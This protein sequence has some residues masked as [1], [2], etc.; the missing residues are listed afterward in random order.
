MTN[1][2]HIKR[3]LQRLDEEVSRCHRMAKF[4][5]DGEDRSLA[6]TYDRDA[7]DLQALRDAVADGDFQ[8]AERIANKVDT[9]VRD[10]IPVRL[11]NTICKIAEEAEGED[12]MTT[13]T[14]KTTKKKAAKK[15]NSKTRPQGKKAAKATANAK[16]G[17]K[18]A[19]SRKDAEKGGGKLSCLDAAAKVLAE[20]KTAMT[21]RE[22]FDAMVAKGY[23]TSDVPTPQNTIYSA[24]LREINI[25]GKDSRFCK[26]ERGR[27]GLN[28]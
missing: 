22:M 13:K 23:W 1:K 26:V 27:F 25:R 15:N 7:A 11:Y 24:I 5:R 4:H 2:A 20:S 18:P 14:R 19:A 8:Y 16:T 9:L 12:S 10:Q 17:K 6:E 21:T 28:K 3:D